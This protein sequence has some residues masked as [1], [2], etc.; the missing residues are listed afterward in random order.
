MISE[1]SGLFDSKQFKNPIQN[2]NCYSEHLPIQLF[3]R[4]ENCGLLNKD[5]F[6]LWFSLDEILFAHLQITPNGATKRL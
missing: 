4:P 3:L 1:W 5:C 6:L 2:V